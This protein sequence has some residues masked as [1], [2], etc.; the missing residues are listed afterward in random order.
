[1]GDI[2]IRRGTIEDAERVSSLVT[3][4][5]EEFIVNEFTADGR[6]HFLK[7]HSPAEVH[8]RLAG[9]FRFYLA[10]DGNDLAAVAAIR[11]NTH[12]YYLF[13][14]KPYQR[15]GLARRLWSRV[16]E[17]AMAQGNAG[18]FTINA[19]NYAVAAYERLGFRRTEPTQEKNGVLHNPMR[20]VSAG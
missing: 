4:L 13:V 1:M 12:L 3:A 18:V 11:G 7:E 14:S 15:M 16:K 20:L 19:S 10:E 6:A 17:E 5:S 9:D 2:A 8:Q